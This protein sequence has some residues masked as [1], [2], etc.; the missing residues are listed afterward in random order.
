MKITRITLAF[1]CRFSLAFF[2][3]IALGKS[4]F[5]GS[6]LWFITSL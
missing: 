1:L 4:G 6:Y 2:D 3:S 5:G